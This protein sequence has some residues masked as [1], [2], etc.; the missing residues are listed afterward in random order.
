MHTI[1]TLELK[2]DIHYAVTTWHEKM[3]FE[4]LVNNHSIQLDKLE[5][6]GGQNKGPRPKLLILSAIGGCAGME[7][8]SILDK[9][10]IKIDGLEIIVTGE[11]NDTQPKI[12]KSIRILFN[13]ESKNSD[14]R[15]V[16]S[17]IQLAIEKYCGVVAMAKHFAEV[18]SE[19]NFV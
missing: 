1:N 9:M 3:H 8:I 17:A 10:R 14:K 6:N 15:K 5:I 16:E 12:Y 11:L 7:I 2:K 13:I 4:S 19:I 18:I